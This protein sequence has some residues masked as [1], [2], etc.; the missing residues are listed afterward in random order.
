M[1]KK[2]KDTIRAWMYVF[3]AVAAVVLGVL[4]SDM[5]FRMIIG[6][7]GVY[8]LVMAVINFR[9]VGKDDMG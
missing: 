4:F 3:Y 6:A 5:T 8:S 2:T 1:E 7:V 9:K